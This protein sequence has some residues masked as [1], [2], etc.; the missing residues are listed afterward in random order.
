MGDTS[1]LAGSDRR[2][3]FLASVGGFLRPG[4]DTAREGAAGSTL[5]AVVGGVVALA[6]VVVA[7]RRR[8][9]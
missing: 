9:R 6:V 7:A 2:P 3:P 5:L 8:S 4:H 1:D